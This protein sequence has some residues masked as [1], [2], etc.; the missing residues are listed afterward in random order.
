M[1]TLGHF[2]E[3]L[4][5]LSYLLWWWYLHLGRIFVISHVD[6]PHYLWRNAF[7]VSWMLFYPTDAFPVSRPNTSSTYQK[8][9]RRTIH[10]D[11]YQEIGSTT[12]GSS[13]IDTSRI[14][15]GNVTQK[16]DYHFF[17][18]LGKK[19]LLM[20]I[21]QI[22]FCLNTEKQKFINTIIGR[23]SILLGSRNYHI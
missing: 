20:F 23:H 12:E 1:Q 8:V 2:F 14:Q 13:L 7:H 21:S 18:P 16:E 22:S 10:S 3:P 4:Y 15:K 11:D 9:E 6:N 17:L 19:I 5:S